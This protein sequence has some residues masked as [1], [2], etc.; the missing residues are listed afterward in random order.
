MKRAL[1]ISCIFIGLIFLQANGQ[2]IRRV[3]LPPHPL[4]NSEMLPFAMHPAWSSD[5][6]FRTQGLASL[7]ITNGSFSAFAVSVPGFQ[8]LTT[9]NTD[10]H[11]Q[12]ERSLEYYPGLRAY[13]TD[14]SLIARQYAQVFR[15]HFRLAGGLRL[16][17]FLSISGWDLGVGAGLRGFRLQT[18]NGLELI[19][20]NEINGALTFALDKYSLGVELDPVE[21]AIRLGFRRPGDLQLSLATNINHQV[22][23]AFGVQLHGEKIFRESLRIHG[24]WRKQYVG[25]ISAED[26]ILMGTYLRFRPFRTGDPAWLKFLLEPSK[27]A[28][29]NRLILDWEVGTEIAIDRQQGGAEL[30]LHLSRWF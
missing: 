5:L 14:S 6:A 12:G 29:F 2:G 22:S 18:E 13:F 4:A 8:V 20:N 26:Q 17:Q 25:K 1:S 27:S 3:G 21:T 23:M 24:G 11:P 19:A 28:F 7:T 10:F 15:D 16:G 9:R 30:V